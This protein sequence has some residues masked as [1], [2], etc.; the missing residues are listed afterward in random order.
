[1]LYVPAG[2]TLSDEEIMLELLCAGCCEGNG[3]CRALA[4]L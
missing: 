1:M 3:V 4:V 2:V